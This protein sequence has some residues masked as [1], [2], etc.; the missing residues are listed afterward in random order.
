MNTKSQRNYLTL[1]VVALSAL[2][3]VSL[4]AMSG[5]NSMAQKREEITGMTM[6]QTGMTNE[7]GMTMNQTATGDGEYNGK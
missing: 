5:Q 7:T 3:V 6:N 1:T 4:V 2:L